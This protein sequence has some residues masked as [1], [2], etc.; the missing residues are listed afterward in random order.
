MMI[1]MREKNSKNDILKYA[2]ELF[3]S[4][5]YEAVSPNEIVEKVGVTKPTLYY[6]FGSKEGLFNE[7]LK[8]NYCKLDDLLSDTCKYTPNTENYYE[9]VYPVLLQIANTFFS[10]AQDNTD[11][12]MMILSMSFVPPES[13]TAQISEQYHKNHYLLVENVFH[14]ISAVHTNLKGKEGICSWM[15]LAMINAQI[16]FWYRGCGILDEKAAISIVTQFMHGIFS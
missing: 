8:I 12:Y 1:S 13:K 2:L 9:D 10:Y 14:E 3:A 5:G 7:L 11:F 16:G 4:K 6:F 15:F